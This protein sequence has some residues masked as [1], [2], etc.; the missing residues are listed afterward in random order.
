MSL[1]SRQ[2]GS[3]ARDWK[4]LFSLS[5]GS[6]YISF[7]LLM[8]PCK[9][10]SFTFFSLLIWDISAISYTEPNMSKDSVV[11]P[12]YSTVALVDNDPDACDPWD[13]PELKDMGPKW[14]GEL[15]CRLVCLWH[16]QQS[17]EM[18]NALKGVYCSFLFV[19][20]SM[21]IWTQREKLSVSLPRLEGLFC[22]LDFFTCLFAPWISWARHFNLLVVSDNWLLFFLFCFFY[23]N[24]Y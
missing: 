3:T 14:S 11:L 5:G 24:Y 16:T 8:L 23:W 13:L 4:W 9:T 7:F 19:V 10:L 12:A 22:W 21:Q 1:S 6:R 17:S 20:L 18:W 15:P 2:N